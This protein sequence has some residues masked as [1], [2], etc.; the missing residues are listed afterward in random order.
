ALGG[1]GGGGARARGGRPGGRRKTPRLYSEAQ[2]RLGETATLLGVAQVLSQPAPAGEVM[3]RLAREVARAFGADMVG[4]Y[5][6]DERKE[7]LV[8]TAGYHVPKHLV[9]VFLTRPFVLERF[10]VLHDVWR[11][12]R[13]FWSAD[14]KNDPRI[15]PE[16]FAGVEPHSVL[17]T[18]TMVRG[19]AVGALFLVGW[20]TGRQ[21]EPAEIRLIE[22]VA[23][24]V[25]LAMENAD[26]A[27]QTQQKLEETERLLAVSRTL[28]STLDLDTVPRQFL[29]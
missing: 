5:L 15:D 19:E 24:Q 14:V 9:Q 22:G 17:F 18:P 6:M 23:V 25:G 27:R 12:G 2:E 1:R 16:T 26:L 11:S 20:G 29:R 13:A 10:P 8:P 4:V 3:R 7:A 21:F 28:A